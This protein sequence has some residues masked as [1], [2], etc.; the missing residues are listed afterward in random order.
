[1]KRLHMISLSVMTLSALQV[2]ASSDYDTSLVN[3]YADDAVV[4]IQAITPEAQPAQAAETGLV[5]IANTNPLA[6]TPD[7][8]TVTMQDMQAMLTSPAA[9]VATANSSAQSATA[10]TTETQKAVSAT[11]V[12]PTTASTT[13]VT[14][15]AAQQ[16]AATNVENVSTTSVSSQADAVQ[17]VVNSTPAQKVVQS[18]TKEESQPIAEVTSVK[19]APSETQ[20]TSEQVKII[21]VYPVYD[22]VWSAV[23]NINRAAHDMI[24]YVYNFIT[25]PRPA[26]NTPGQEKV[27]EPVQK[28]VT[29]ET[30]EPVETATDTTESIETATEEASTEKPEDSSKEDRE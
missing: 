16:V 25:Q 28:E 8:K 10:S 1:M 24:N 15:S 12:V 23:K 17:A 27:V 30:T 2:T 6:P 3:N 29:A 19:T 22:A 9:P 14:D 5:P 20:S 4:Q 21:K 7:N 18:A 26:K 11:Q 13:P